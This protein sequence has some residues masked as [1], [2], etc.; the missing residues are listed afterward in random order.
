MKYL[1]EN[2]AIADHNESHSLTA[3]EN[4]SVAGT[5]VPQNQKNDEL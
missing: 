1:Y 5:F 2:T 3:G 4:D